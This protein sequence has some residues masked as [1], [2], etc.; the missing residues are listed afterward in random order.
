MASIQPYAP[1]KSM[2]DVSVDATAMLIGAIGADGFIGALLDFCKRGV[3]ANFVSVFSRRREGTPSLIGTATT[4][5]SINTRKASEGYMQH[6]LDDVNFQ[7][8]SKGLE[9]GSFITYQA[10]SDIASFAYRRACYDRTG[11]ADRFSFVRT[12]RRFPLSINLYRS[13][14]VSQFS[15]LDRARMIGLMPI[16]IA[17]VDRHAA[18]V[19]DKASGSI[20][21]L[22]H[23]LGLRFTKLTRRE[24]EVAARVKAGMS[25]SAI[26]RDLNIAETTVI[27]HRKSAYAR[28]GASNMRDLMR[29]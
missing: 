7:L 20:E 1:R 19:A 14:S 25:A 17:A 11:I 28:L 29:L 4:T 9:K 26:A 23:E 21:G 22:E 2:Q 3:G 13:R 5:S 24:C 18:S 8:M 15:D 10:A 16:L 12:T 27:S 6:F